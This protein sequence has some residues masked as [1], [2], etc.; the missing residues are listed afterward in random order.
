[1]FSIG[2]VV[3]QA[4]G[5]SGHRRAKEL[6]V[7]KE[8]L[9]AEKCRQRQPE[10]APQREAEVGTECIDRAAGK[11]LLSLEGCERDQRTSPAS[12]SASPHA[13]RLCRHK[14]PAL[15]AGGLGDSGSPSRAA[16]GRPS[17]TSASAAGL[18]AAG[19]ALPGP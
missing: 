4:A 10:Q 8:Q 6:R 3:E 5:G 19:V 14:R 16:S 18:A 11:D 17:T 2:V 15:H 1:M 13:A 9:R 7:S 12:A